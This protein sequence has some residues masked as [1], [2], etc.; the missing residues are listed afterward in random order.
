M[1]FVSEW[2]VYVYKNWQEKNNIPWEA[3]PGYI[4]LVNAYLYT[5]KYFD[6]YTYP[7][8]LKITS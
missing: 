5:L 3:I 7:D 6:N 8:D 2:C 4:N 1:E